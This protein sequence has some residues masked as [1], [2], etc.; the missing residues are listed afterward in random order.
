MPGEGRTIA[1]F[2][3][4]VTGPFLLLTSAGFILG[5]ILL[6]GGLYLLYSGLT[7]LG[8]HRRVH[9]WRDIPNL[10]IPG[11]LAAAPPPPPPPP[12]PPAAATDAAP[13]SEADTPV[14]ICASCGTENP[15]AAAYC[16]KCNAP[17]PPPKHL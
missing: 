13:T 2:F 17:L 4:V 6:L 3:F 7:T 10:V 8:V 9:S 5:V 12:P 15:N 11:T 1:G 16:R 14:K